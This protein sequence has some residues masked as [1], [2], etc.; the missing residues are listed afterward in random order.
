MKEI[1]EALAAVG[2]AVPRLLL[3]AE[4]VDLIR[5][6]VVACDQFTAQPAYWE[7]VEAL[8]GEAPSALRLML[9]EAWLGRDDARRIDAVNAAMER[10][11][12]SG[13]LADIGECMVYLR[14]ETG[15]GVRRGLVLALDLERYDYSPQSR[16]LIRA[17]EGTIVDRLP[18]RVRIRRDAPLEMPHIMALIDDREDRLM[19]L[20]EGEVNRLERL[21][22]FPL[23]LGG[24]RLTGWRVDRPGLLLE[25]AQALT[26]LLARDPGGLLYAM[27][28]GNHSFAAAKACW[29]ELKPSL[30]PAERARHPARHALVELVNLHDPALDFEPIHRLLYRVDPSQVQRDLGFDAARPP[31]LQALQPLLDGWL[32]RH[33]ESGLEYI[34]GAHDC[35]AL[36]DAPDRL[37][38]VFPEFDKASFFE[39]VR[40]DGA[41]VRK[42]FSMG[43]ARDKRYYLECRRIR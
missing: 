19:G 12:S 8:V 34:H 27:G 3:P 26:S 2:A 1:R 41:Y 23:M 30:T 31:S 38:I 18:P 17:T 29:E 10:Y 37:A 32:S 36:G 20:L 9:P 40:R 21:Y 25:V 5:F 33:P 14:R 4:A 42:S 35:R 13:T 7:E 28:D 11:L 15:G 39:V 22:D 6:S 43:G 16:S 24:G